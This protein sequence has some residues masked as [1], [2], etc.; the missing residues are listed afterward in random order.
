MTDTTTERRALPDAAAY[1]AAFDAAWRV[2]EAE[3]AR[4]RAAYPGWNDP[5][6]PD[7]S[8]HS[9]AYS[10]EYRAVDDRRVSALK[11]AWSTL[12]RSEDPLLA[13]VTGHCAGFRGPIEAALR[14]MPASLDDLDELAAEQD[15]CCVWD[16]RDC[17][18]EDC[19]GDDFRAQLI[20]ESFFSEERSDMPYAGRV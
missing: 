19:D 13:W 8:K 1:I 12:C 18:D 14:I 2:W 17:D 15:W 16:A 20:D 7:W 10:K 4:L 11:A 3:D 9:M 6:S 5:D